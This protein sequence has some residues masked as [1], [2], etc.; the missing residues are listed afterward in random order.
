ELEHSVIDPPMMYK[1]A[2]NRM[3]L[4]LKADHVAVAM[5]EEHPQMGPICI[6]RQQSNL[7]PKPVEAKPEVKVK[8]VMVNGE[9]MEIK[10]KVEK[11]D[12]QPKLLFHKPFPKEP[13]KGGQLPDL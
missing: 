8:R 11:E 5:F 13:P 10:E 2:A 12:D 6:V 9:V 3:K 4:M 7:P 1:L